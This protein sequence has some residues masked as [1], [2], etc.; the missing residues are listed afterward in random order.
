MT[1]EE[2]W[3]AYDYANK[4]LSAANGA[5]FEL[6][7]VYFESHAVIYG[8]SC[9]WATCQGNPE[10]VRAMDSAYDALVV[11][12]SAVVAARTAMDAACAA[13]KTFT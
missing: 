6:T 9:L 5:V 13:Y 3:A 8:T 1:R 12:K 10:G 7:G 11:A 4:A 2:A